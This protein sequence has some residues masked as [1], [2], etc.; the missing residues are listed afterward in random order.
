MFPVH[1]FETK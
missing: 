1:I